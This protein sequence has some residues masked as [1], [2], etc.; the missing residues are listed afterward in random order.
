MCIRDSIFTHDSFGV[1]EDGPTHQPVEQLASLR[2]IP[3]LITLRPADANEVVEAWRTIMQLRHEPVA[4]LLSRQALPTFDRTKYGAAT[5]LQK[6]AYILAGDSAATPD[7]VFLAT[8]SE[9]ALCVE[10]HETL[11]AEGVSS[12]VVSMPSWELFEQQTQEYRDSVIPN[13]DTVM[14]A[15]EQAARLGWERYVGRNGAI[16]A[17]ETFGASAPLKELQTKFGFTPKRLVETAR[18]R[19]AAKASA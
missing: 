18:S 2:C 19:L 11:T 8:G 15:V 4:M 9:V 14:I 7:V 12:R 5:G 13:D 17:M 10:A 1:G 16:I 3:G 6:G